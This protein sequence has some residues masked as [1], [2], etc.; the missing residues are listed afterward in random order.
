[1]TSDSEGFL[2]FILYLICLI[3]ILEKKPVFPFLMLIAEQGNYPVPYSK[4]LWYDTVLD[5]G[6][7][8]RSPALD[9]STLPL[10]YRGGGMS[11]TKALENR[12][13]PNIHKLV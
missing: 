11:V 3:F 2:D 7:S 4:H 8:M 13:M 6:L 9:A 1:M 12:V 10:G 5:C